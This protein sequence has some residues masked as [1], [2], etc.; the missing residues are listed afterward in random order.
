M[1]WSAPR[2]WSVSEIVTASMM[3][4]HVR[5]NLDYLKGNAGAV[6]ISDALQVEKAT[7]DSQ[8]YISS[9]SPRLAIGNHATYASRTLSARWVMATTGGDYGLTTAG[10]SQIFTEGINGGTAGRLVLGANSSLTQLVLATNGNVGMGVAAPQGK[11]HLSGPG[12]GGFMV[13]SANDVTS[14]Q[15]IAIAGTVTN[16]MSAWVF[17]RNNTGGAAVL[18]FNGQAFTLGSVPTYTNTDTIEVSLTAGGAITVRRSV[19]TNGSHDITM[20]VLYH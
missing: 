16:G 4:T 11:L 17:D 6:V 9:V 5:D 19:G 15:T 8:F 18:G 1:T 13:L 20:F 3:N 2:T 7:A 14:I 10:D 12:G